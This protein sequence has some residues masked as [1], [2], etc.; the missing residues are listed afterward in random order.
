M[1]E[2]AG[3]AEAR[4]M[5]R[6][7]G[8]DWRSRGGSVGR[9]SCRRGAVHGCQGRAA[10][11]AGKDGAAHRRTGTAKGRPHAKTARALKRISG[12]VRRERREWVQH[13]RVQ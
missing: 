5:G 7:L 6:R 4:H 10:T 9:E 3:R 12:D 13:A 11:N 2:G 8:S 1:Q